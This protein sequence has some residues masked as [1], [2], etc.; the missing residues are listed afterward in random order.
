[1]PTRATTP[2]RPT[3]SPTSRRP[4]G[5]S[6]GSTRAAITAIVSGTAA[7]M[8]AASEEETNFSP[9]GMALKGRTI[10]M[11]AKA[12]TARHRLLTPRSAPRRQATGSRTAAPRATRLQARN[13]GWTSSTATLMKKYGTPH[14]TETVAK[15][16]QARRLTTS[17]ARSVT[18]SAPRILLIAASSAA[19]GPAAPALRHQQLRPPQIQCRGRLEVLPGSLDHP[20]GPAHRLD[21]RGVVG[22]RGED[23]VGLVERPL[24]RVA[25]ER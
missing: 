1:M 9:T 3:K 17:D 12:T 6:D 11:T 4:R 15:A 13:S 19:D 10:S 2:V 21:E 5:R 14:S 7:I 8:I 25:A 20:H 24:Q 23:V 22:S 16:I 18:A